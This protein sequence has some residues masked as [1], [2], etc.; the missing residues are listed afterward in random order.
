VLYQNVLTTTITAQVRGTLAAFTL[1]QELVIE[2]GATYQLSV[3]VRRRD[4]SAIITSRPGRYAAGASI[5]TDATEDI[6]L[7]GE[8]GRIENATLNEDLF[9]R[10]LR[11][12]RAQF[13]GTD[14][15]LLALDWESAW[16]ERVTRPDHPAHDAAVQ[17]GARAID[18][19]REEWP[20]AAI[21]F[22]G[23]PWGSPSPTETWLR[24]MEASVKPIFDR[25]DWFAPSIYDKA[26]DA[27]S[28]SRALDRAD[29]RQESALRLAGRLAVGR[30]ILPW[31]THRFF[32]PGAGFHS[33][34]VEQH[35]FSDHLRWAWRFNE[36]GERVDGFVF[37]YRDR[38]I[39][40]E[41]RIRPAGSDPQKAPDAA[42]DAIELQYGGWIR[43]IMAEPR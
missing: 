22:Y 15:P 17:E 6:T 34:L 8:P 16:L 36:N 31:V 41:Q 37:W 23:C 33:E 2:S 11:K 27:A 39:W 42:L 24:D 7:N 12:K 10:A 14:R 21:T 38:D 25:V 9:R 18:I 19:A 4:Y 20:E 5:T 40:Q 13:K 43:D 1:D 30:P 28:S 3:D 29:R 26:K 32:Q 35:E